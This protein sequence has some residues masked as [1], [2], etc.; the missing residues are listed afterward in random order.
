M[1]ASHSI[2]LSLC[3]PACLP[4]LLCISLQWTSSNYSIFDNAMKW[5]QFNFPVVMCGHESWT[6]K[7]AEHWRTDAFK[8]W[9]CRRLLRVPWT[10]K[11]FN[12]SILKEINPEYLLEGLMLKLKPQYFGHQMWKANSLEKTLKLGKIE[13]RRRRGSRGWDGWRASVTQWT[14]IWATPGNSEGQG[15]LACCS[16]WGCKVSEMAYWLNNNKILWRKQIRSS[17]ILPR[18]VEAYKFWTELVTSTLPVHLGFGGTWKTSK[19]IS[20]DVISAGQKARISGLE[21]DKCAS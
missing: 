19:S 21:E 4:V 1:A 2:T 3:L 12:Q 9:C 17:S 10:V 7:K 16:S 5:V 13:D 18:A 6:I 15:S 8:L 20:I 14:W 11:R